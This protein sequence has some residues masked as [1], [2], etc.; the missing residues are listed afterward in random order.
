[1]KRLPS[2]PS[3]CGALAERAVI[4]D[5]AMGT[6]LQAAVVYGYFRAVS[7]GN[8][9]IV[10]SKTGAELERFTRYFSV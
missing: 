10:L 6:M 8:D 2:V 5:G 9:L 1:V 3:P 4:S 7:E